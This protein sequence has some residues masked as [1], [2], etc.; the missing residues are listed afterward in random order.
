MHPLESQ[1]RTKSNHTVRNHE[2]L[3]PHHRPHNGTHSRRGRTHCR[4]SHHR[5]ARR[6]GWLDVVA[7][8]EHHTPPFFSS[9]PTTTLTRIATNT[10]KIQLSTSTTLITPN[11]PVKNAEDYAMVQYMS[12]GQIDLMMGHGNT[13]PVYPWFR[14][15]I[16]NSIPLAIENYALLRR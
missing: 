4:N 15:D 2:R 8:G 1:L 16:R 6:R 12:G 9:S 3:R 5:S 14:K 7:I 13:G 10:S 11:N